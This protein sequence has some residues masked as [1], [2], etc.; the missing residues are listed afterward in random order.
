[1]KT[2]S[3]QYKWHILLGIFVVISIFPIVFAIS[4]SF[5]EL[6]EAYSNVLSLIP[7]NPT[8]EN[9]RQV[10]LRLP[11]KK[12][13]ENTFFIAVCVTGFKLLTS[14]LAAYAFVYFDFKGKNLL[15]Y[16]E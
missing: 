10:F 4:S 2:K 5:K 13:T 7:K 6:N 3:S 15:Y 14:V 1:M 12:I 16:Q 11:F 9:Y 8:I